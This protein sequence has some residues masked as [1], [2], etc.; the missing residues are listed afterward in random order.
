[1]GWGSDCKAVKKKAQP[2]WL[3]GQRL[4]LG[5]V[6]CRDPSLSLRFPL[7]VTSSSPSW[8]LTLYLASLLGVTISADLCEAQVLCLAGQS[9]PHLWVPALLQKPPQRDLCGPRW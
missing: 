7:W 5:L 6:S 9:W 1:M 8:P 4:S 2:E 3:T